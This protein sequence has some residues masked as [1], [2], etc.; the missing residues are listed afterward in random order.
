MCHSCPFNSHV[1][2]SVQGCTVEYLGFTRNAIASL[3]DLEEL[4]S[5]PGDITVEDEH[6]EPAFRC[7]VFFFLSCLS[8]KNL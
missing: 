5:L 4:K 3:E 8:L 7:H 1:S 6:I 2:G